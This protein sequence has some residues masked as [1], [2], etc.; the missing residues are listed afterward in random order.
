MNK[1]FESSRAPEPVG[2]FPHAKRVGNFLFLSGIGPR[3]R[4]GKE[5]P[6]VTLDPAGSGLTTEEAISAATINGAHALGCAGRV[7]SLEP[8]KSADL[9]LL[10]ANDYRDLSGNLGTNLVHMTMKRGRFIYKEGP[11]APRSPD[12]L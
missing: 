6:G 1:S 9:I 8:G 3:A 4:G 2:A 11:V 12:A 5:I 7:G 10:N